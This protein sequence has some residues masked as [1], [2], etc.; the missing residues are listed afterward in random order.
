M[1]KSLLFRNRGGSFCKICLWVCLLLGVTSVNAQ[2]VLSKK[3]TLELKD[4]P[5]IEVLLE[6]Q[7]QTDVNFAYGKTHLEQLKPVTLS[8]KQMP[9]EEVLKIVLKDTGFE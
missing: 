1:K 8:V 4:A 2:D 6:I 5:I 3:I 7:K 9:L